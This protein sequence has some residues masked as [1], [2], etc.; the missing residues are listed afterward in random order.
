KG[1]NLYVCGNGGSR[2]QHAKLLVAD[3]DKESCIRYIDRFLMFYIKTADPLTRT[4]TWL[5]K[6]EG[7]IEY[8]KDVVVNDSLGIAEQLEKEMQELIAAYHCEWK[9]VVEDPA[10]KAGFKHFINSEG[11]DPAMRFAEVRGQKVPLDWGK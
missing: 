3:T 2:P 7:G 6:T 9:K 8:L 5:N 1:W 4:A 10:L 11:P